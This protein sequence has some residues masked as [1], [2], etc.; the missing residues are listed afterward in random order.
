MGVWETD[1]REEAMQQGEQ[2]KAVENALFILKQIFFLIF[3][4]LI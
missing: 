3:L 4:I 2:K 1:I